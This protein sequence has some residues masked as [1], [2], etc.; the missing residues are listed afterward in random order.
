MALV[1]RLSSAVFPDLTILGDVEYRLILPP[2]VLSW[3]WQYR[4]RYRFYQKLFERV[5]SKLA[6]GPGRRGLLK[7]CDSVY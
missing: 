1:P 3:T 7:L 6:G 2:S 4:C 5:W